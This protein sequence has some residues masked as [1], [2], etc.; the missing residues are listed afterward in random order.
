MRLTAAAALIT[1]TQ[2]LV[3]PPQQRRQTRLH[4]RANKLV[5]W[6]CDGVLVDSEALYCRFV[7]VRT[8]EAAQSES[9][10]YVQVRARLLWRPLPHP[11]LGMAWAHDTAA[12]GTV[13]P[14]RRGRG[15]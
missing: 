10:D 4:G 15:C 9:E 6:D 3:A 13:A 7:R 2:A 8:D 1:A 5:I 14:S 11:T 12:P